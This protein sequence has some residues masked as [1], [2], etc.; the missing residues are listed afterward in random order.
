MVSLKIKTKKII[1]KKVKINKSVRKKVKTKKSVVKK[2]KVA[3]CPWFRRRDIKS[4]DEW[5]FTPV[6][7][8]GGVTLF[9]LFALNIFAA[10]YFNLQ[11][12]VVDNYLKMGVVFFLSLFVFIEIAKKKTR[13]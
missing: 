8:K 12:F 13:R 6:N 7:W 11:E 3:S 10:N 5:G 1:G 2:I 4:K 9:L